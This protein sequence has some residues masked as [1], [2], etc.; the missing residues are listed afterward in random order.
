ML[1]HLPTLDSIDSIA[2]KSHPMLVKTSAA[3]TMCSMSPVFIRKN[4]G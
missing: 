3:R 2:Q 4:P 1:A